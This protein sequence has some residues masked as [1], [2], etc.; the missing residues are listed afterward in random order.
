MATQNADNF[1]NPISVNTGG[2][3]VSSLV[4][5]APLTGGTTTTGPVQQATTNF[6]K[7]G[8]VLN[9]N[10]ASSLPSWI[11]QQGAIVE[12]STQTAAA[13][14]AL[15]FN[16]T[17]ITSTYTNYLCVFKGINGIG[18][19]QWE[20]LVSTDNGSTFVSTYQSTNLNYNYNSASA[21]SFTNTAAASIIRAT[22][23]QTAINGYFY[24]NFPPSAS[25]SYVGKWYEV[26]GTSQQ[27]KCLGG[28][29]TTTTINYMRVQGASG[30]FSG[31]V[32]LYGIK[33]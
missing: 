7:S 20:F 28:S 11:D 10:G 14:S 2:L 33:S 1:T 13:S 32:T 8:F 19:I 6:A 29:S 21:S 3:G 5:Y 18:N 15:N 17:I 23:G 30:T 24:V 31:T 4:A 9:S 25:F 22:T 27:G 12:L 16:N 26:M